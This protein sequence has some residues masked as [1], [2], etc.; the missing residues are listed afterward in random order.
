VARDKDIPSEGRHEILS[1]ISAAVNE[2]KHDVLFTIS[3]LA[4][5]VGLQFFRAMDIPGVRWPLASPLASK[6]VVSD[7]I[8]LCLA[9]LALVAIYDCIRVMFLLHS[10]YEEIAQ[11]TI[12]RE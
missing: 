10:H 8:A 2:V 1:L 9:G 4:V 11:Q 5:V 7:A 6:L 3:A 12:G